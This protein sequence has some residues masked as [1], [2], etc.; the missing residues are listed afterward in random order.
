MAAFGKVVAGQ[1]GRHHVL[2]GHVVREHRLCPRDLFHL[3]P[4]LKVVHEGVR[5]ARYPRRLRVLHVDDHLAGCG[6][7]GDGAPG[8]ELQHVAPKLHLPL[9]LFGPQRACVHV[10]AQQWTNNFVAKARRNVKAYF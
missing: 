3:L 10:P 8:P 4:R 9:Q 5:A 2:D 1:E 7:V 6:L